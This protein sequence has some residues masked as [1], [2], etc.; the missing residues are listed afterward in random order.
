MHLVVVSGTTGEEK[1]CA[2]CLRQEASE[3]G[4]SFLDFFRARLR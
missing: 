4:K 3:G 1:Y 2:A